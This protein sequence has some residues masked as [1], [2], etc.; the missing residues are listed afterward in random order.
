MGGALGSA[1]SGS[2]A[3]AVVSRADLTSGTAPRGRPCPS[4]P[5]DCGCPPRDHAAPTGARRARCASDARSR[6]PVGA[7]DGCRCASGDRDGG[8]GNAV[9]R[10]LEP[11]RSST[12]GSPRTPSLQATAG[13][14]LGDATHPRAPDLLS[15]P[16]TGPSDQERPT[17]RCV[18]CLVQGRGVTA[19]GR[20]QGEEVLPSHTI[21]Y[22]PHSARRCC[23]RAHGRPP[24]PGRHRRRR[25]FPAPARP[26]ARS[27]H[28][29]QRGEVK[30]AQQKGGWTGRR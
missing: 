19:R 2:R 21:T 15:T 18:S 9:D 5:A 14:R 10:R 13:W 20:P 22:I 26:R 11:V 29:P 4:P 25:L 23:W 8:A 30:G 28:Q 6:R 3:C 16:P 12:R 17:A 1:A 7:P 24:L 27:S